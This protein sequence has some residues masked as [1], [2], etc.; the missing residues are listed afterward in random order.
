[1]KKLHLLAAVVLFLLTGCASKL[2]SDP[3]YVSPSQ[4]S[5]YNC[6]QLKLEMQRVSSNLE[7]AKKDDA[8]GQI[9]GAALRVFAISQ[10]YRLDDSDSKLE[11][12]R[13][14]NQ[15]TVL[16]QALIKKECD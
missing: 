4:Y 9:L 5:D 1:M 3:A 15:Y 7:Q 6:K 11:S 13:L 8:T 16:S 12:R 14:Q 10:G 2:A